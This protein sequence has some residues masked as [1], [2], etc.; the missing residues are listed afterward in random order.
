M[1]SRSKTNGDSA[2]RLY[3]TLERIPG[4]QPEV[5]ALLL[6]VVLVSIVSA[7]HEPWFDEA[8]AWQ[9]AKLAP[10]RDI[11]FVIPHFEGHPPLW[12]LLLALPARLGAPYETTIKSINI[13]L[14]TLAVWVLLFR[15]PFPRLIRL[16]LPFTY[17]LFY[18]YGVFARPYS[19]MVLAFMLVAVAYASKDRVPFRY[20]LALIL[21]C[22]SSAYG[23]VFA[24]GLALVWLI[25][26]IRATGLRSLLR[27]LTKDRRIHALGVLLL[28]A[29]VNI[30][31]ILPQSD[32]YAMTPVVTRN[33]LLIRLIYTFFI[34]PADACFLDCYSV[35][36]DLRAATFQTGTFAI[37]V[38][39]GLLFWAVLLFLS[40]RRKNTL[41]LVLPYTLFAVFS[42]S[43]YFWNHHIGIAALFLL[44]WFWID[45]TSAEVAELQTASD[46]TDM[47]KPHTQ[48]KAHELAHALRVFCGVLILS[49]SVLWT[50]VASCNDI[51]YPYGYGRAAAAYLKQQGLD[52]PKIF[53]N[54]GEKENPATGELVIDT[55]FS[56][57]V[58]IL[59]YFEHNVIKSLNRGADSMAYMTHQR[60]DDATNRQNFA[61]WA[62]EGAPDALLASVDLDRIFGDSLT[63][64]DYSPVFKVGQSTIWKT[65]VFGSCFFIY[66]RND[67]IRPAD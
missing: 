38:V 34:L 18:Q 10:I 46:E 29:L 47:L 3:Q 11:L 50:L 66:L 55:N 57:G 65:N 58:T 6:F 62:E 5:I 49:V 35:D 40:S 25:Q 31:L 60:T 21:L 15:A 48:A 16:V 51:L 39:V 53:C 59:P 61:V 32:A 43:V 23:I 63:M 7:F 8:Q 17:F 64:A 9:I 13:L 44:F 20:V 2:L 37:G 1:T 56:G 12:H 36:M 33:N 41:L 54:W 26:L 28:V 27:G 52:N 14:S 22:L 67:L 45:A 19:L 30:W 42:A 4:K 24:G